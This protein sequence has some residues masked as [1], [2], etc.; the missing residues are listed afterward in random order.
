[1]RMRVLREKLR[2]EIENE[3]RVFLESLNF[4]IEMRVSQKSCLQI[5]NSHKVVT[6]RANFSE[7]NL[8]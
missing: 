7:A 1:M 4:E 5:K 8:A 2:V 3:T 6:C